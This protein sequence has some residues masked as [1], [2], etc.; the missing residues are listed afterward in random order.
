VPKASD[1]GLQ[2]ESEYV[3][4]FEIRTDNHGL[5]SVFR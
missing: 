1:A 4:G 2:E 3:I 5:R